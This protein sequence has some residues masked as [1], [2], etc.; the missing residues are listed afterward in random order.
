H[1]CVFRGRACVVERLGAGKRGLT[2]DVAEVLDRDRQARQRRDDQARLAHRV[3]G[4][5]GGQR[6]VVPYLDEG[7][8]AL[9]LGVFD[10]GERLLGELARAGA[11]RG[12]IRGELLDG[13]I[14]GVRFFTRSSTTAGSASVEVSPRLLKSFSAILRRMRR[15]ILP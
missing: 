13:G 7:A 15:M 8:F 5:G 4:I 12:Q 14:H 2:G 3:A 11:A 1:G 9:A 10:A 6:L